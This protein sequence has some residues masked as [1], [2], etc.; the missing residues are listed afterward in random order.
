MALPLARI[1]LDNVDE[2][3]DSPS[4]SRQNIHDAIF[5]VNCI[6]DELNSPASGALIGEIKILTYIP[7][8]IPENWLETA[9]QSLSRTTYAALYGKIG[10]T[11]GG[12][13]SSFNLPN[14]QRRVLVGRGGTGTG[15]LGNAVGNV[16]GVEAVTLT[17]AQMPAHTHSVSVNSVGGHVH[18]LSG[19]SGS[20]NAGGAHS[21]T[22]PGNSSGSGGQWA[23]E[24]RTP[25]GT[26]NTSLA[27]NHSH[28]ITVSG[29]VTSGGGHG[30]TGTCN[31]TGG[32]Q[33]HNNLQPSAICFMMIYTGPTA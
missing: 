32:G 3:G 25:I 27:P 7:V 5:A 33:A 2:P 1:T 21:H 18:G 20:A 31:S 16:G 14:F 6:L 24:N 11:W 26:R 28:T 10:T 23:G 8:P 9:G 19:L 12:S 4:A 15:V 13:G 29:T 22:V 30:H 17:S